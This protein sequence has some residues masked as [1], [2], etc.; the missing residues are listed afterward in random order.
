MVAMSFSTR[1]D[2]PLVEHALDE[3]CRSPSCPGDVTET[4]TDPAE[5][6]PNSGGQDARSLLKPVLVHRLVLHLVVGPSWQNGRLGCRGAAH[7]AFVQL[8]SNA[9]W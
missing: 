6:T 4:I 7:G 3:L 2:V 9:S 8:P 1:R 5:Y